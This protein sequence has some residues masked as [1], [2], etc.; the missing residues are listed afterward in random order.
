MSEPLYIKEQRLIEEAFDRIFK[1][2]I[3]DKRE[4]FVLVE[5]YK[6]PVIIF[7]EEQEYLDYDFGITLGGYRNAEIMWYN[8]AGDLHSFNDMPSKI[9]FG[10]S[11]WLMLQ[12]HKNGIPYRKNSLFNRVV[13][14]ERYSPTLHSELEVIFEWRNNKGE[15]HSFNDMPARISND[16]IEWYWNGNN[17]RRSK[18][19]E[20]PC[21]IHS[22]GQMNFREQ[23]DDAMET[24]NFPLS[25]K[26][27][28]KQTSYNLSQYEKYVKWP[29]RKLLTL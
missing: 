15:L 9:V 5:K 22:T 8:K 13:V 16:R 24:V 19:S 2:K 27:F 1:V 6:I 14:S 21:I 12:W 25:K 7:S 23:K 26:H 17:H 3:F 10:T 28:G 4:R 18:Y 11:D 29:I 20:L